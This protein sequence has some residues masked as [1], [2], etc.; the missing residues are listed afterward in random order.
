MFAG[1]LFMRVQASTCNQF[2]AMGQGKYKGKVSGVVGISCRH[3]FMLAN[4]IIDLIRAEQYVD[5]YGLHI[6][7]MTR[8]HNRYQFVDLALL[9]TLQKYLV[10]L[11]LFGTYDINCQYMVNLRKRL[12]DYGVVLEEIDGLQST[13]LPQIIAGVGK[14]HLSMHTKECR[15]KFSMHLLPGACMFDGEP[16]ERIW[17][18]LNALALRTKEM[19]GGHRHDVLNEHFEDMNLRRLQV[20]GESLRSP[21]HHTADVHDSEGTPRQ[22]CKRKQAC[23]RDREVSC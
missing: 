11:Q 12:A 15:H 6:D 23:Q 14:Y 21:Y 1:G 5:N 19:S 2:G 20:L 9:C 3:M 22:V 10:L 7:L 4:S 18:I 17:A 16:M 8:G 13:E